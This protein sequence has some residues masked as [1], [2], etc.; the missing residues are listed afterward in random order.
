MTPARWRGLDGRVAAVL[1]LGLAA[2]PLVTQ[3]PY[4]LHVCIMI[5]LYGGVAQAWNLLGGYAGQ[6]SIGHIMYFGVGA[7]AGAILWTRYHISPWLAL[8]VGAS[9]AGLL[10][11]GVATIAVRYG[12]RTD[13]YALL[14]LALS[15]ILRLI[16]TN[17]Q[18][19]GGAMGIYVPVT[20]DD[21]A[22]MQ[23]TTKV[24][25]YVI[26]LALLAGMTGLLAIVQTS[27]V[28]A[29]LVAI[30]EN[31]VAAEAVGINTRLYK[32]WSTAVSGALT[33]LVGVVF[34]IYTTFIDPELVLGL[35]QNFEFLLVAIVGGRGSL[36]GP[37]A[38]A[39]LL[40]P[41]SELTRVVF[42]HAPPGF[43]L[44]VFG[45]ALVG[46]VL[47]IPDGVAGLVRV[48]G[49]VLERRQRGPEVA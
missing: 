6:L 32:I 27:R 9:M 2:V 11:L 31:E 24:P 33:A 10:G 7:Y 43:H 20:T 36:A 28:G 21:L 48:A 5:V 16:A 22:T 30:R 44:M 13:Y 35:G 37:L 3:D 29:F 41:L 38:G 46:V 15:Q 49:G 19:L 26:G 25:Y 40:R 34:A 45:A 1:L 39:I 47:V 4:V 12:L 18:S 17:A 8:P 42:G 14:T 23:F